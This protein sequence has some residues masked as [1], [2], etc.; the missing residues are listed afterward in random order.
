MDVTPEGSAATAAAAAAAALMAA[1]SL[2]GRFAGGPGCG[3]TKPNAQF[4]EV[5]FN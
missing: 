4:K 5:A 2:L 3:T 1:T